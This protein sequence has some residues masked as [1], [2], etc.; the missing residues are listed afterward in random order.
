M[1]VEPECHNFGV[2]PIQCDPKFGTEM[3]LLSLMT[4]VER[5]ISDL[6][7]HDKRSNENKQGVNRPLFVTPDICNAMFK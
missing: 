2:G 4:G 5:R 6:E 7:R 3:F 1:E